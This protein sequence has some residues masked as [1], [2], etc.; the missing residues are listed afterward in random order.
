MSITHHLHFLARQ[1][2][3]LAHDPLPPPLSTTTSPSFPSFPSFLQTPG[4]LPSQAFGITRIIVHRS[5]RGPSVLCHCG[6]KGLVL[7]RTQSVRTCHVHPARHTRI[8]KTKSSQIV[9]VSQN[10]V[11]LILILQV[12]V[13]HVANFVPKGHPR[14]SIGLVLVPW[15]M[16]TT[17][18]HSHITYTHTH[19]HIHTP[20]LSHTPLPHC[21][22]DRHGCECRPSGSRLPVDPTTRRCLP[23]IGS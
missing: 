18:H 12:Y 10:P 17:K 14:T 22:T 15:E 4:G 6:H 21:N 13:S 2:F 9:Y 5:L 16:V 20:S 1:S 19:T 23:D 11:G 8:S 3:D 7:A